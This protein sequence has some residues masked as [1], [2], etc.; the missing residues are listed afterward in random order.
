MGSYRERPVHPGLVQLV[1]AVW[2]G[3]PPETGSADR[4]QVLPDGCVDIVVGSNGA[5]HVAGPATVAFD[6]ERRPGDVAFGVRFR[7]GVAEAVL[8]APVDELRD[9]NPDLG[10]FFPIRTV[11]RL[12]AA[13]SRA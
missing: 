1:D 6:V 10:S 5:L 2:I 4:N 13:A 3:G 8:G 11:R 9:A 12:T 7:T